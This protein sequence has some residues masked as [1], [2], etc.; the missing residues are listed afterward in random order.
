MGTTLA[1]TG[2]YDLAGCLQN[3]L[4]GNTPDPSAAFAEYEQRVRETVDTAQQL[5]PGQPRLINPETAWGVWTMRTLIRALSYTRIIF[6]AVRY[7]GR[8]LN[9]GPQ[10]AMFVSVKDYG[11]RDAPEWEEKNV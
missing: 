4:K 3:Y 2:A 10:A 6:I 5:A 8:L 11:F 7:F 9:L 1:F